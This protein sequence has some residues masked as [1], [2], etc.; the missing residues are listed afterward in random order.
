MI[1]HLLNQSVTTAAKSSVSSA[2]DYTFGAQSAV[3]CMLVEKAKQIVNSEGVRV[4]I[5]TIIISETLIDEGAFVWFT[6]D[7]TSDNNAATE[8]LGKTKYHSPS[9]QEIFEAYV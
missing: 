6:G 3:A 2:G 8:I 9:G 4:D 7:D 1:A 5:N